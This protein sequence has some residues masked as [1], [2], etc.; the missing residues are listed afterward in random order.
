MYNHQKIENKWQK[1]WDEEKHLKPM[2]MILI[3]QNI[4]F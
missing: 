2:L 1:H 4:M 3:N